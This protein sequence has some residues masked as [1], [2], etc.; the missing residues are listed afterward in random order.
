MR[1]TN[2]PTTNLLFPLFPFLGDTNLGNNRNI[3]S[4]YC[5]KKNKNPHT[6]KNKTSLIID[7]YVED[8]DSKRH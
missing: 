3:Y 7:S 1:S 8:L 4:I 5:L 6:Y 2:T